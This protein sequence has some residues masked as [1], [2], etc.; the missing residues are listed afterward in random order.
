MD[1]RIRDSVRDFYGDAAREQ[2]PA[3]CCPTSYSKEDTAHIPKEVLDISYGCGSPIG[4]AGVREGETVLDLGSGGGIDCFIA[5]KKVGSSGRVIGVDMTDDM[6][7]KAKE[8]EREVAEKLGFSNVEFKKG[9][10]EEIPVEDGSIDLVTSNCV[11]N[12]SHDKGKVMEEVYRILRHKGRF[13]ISDVVSEKEVPEKM[14]AD[15][16]LWG[17][18]ISGAL[19]EDD[20]IDMSRKAGFYGLHVESRYLYHEVEGMSFHSITLKGYKFDK[21]AECLYKGQYAIYHGPF[22]SVHDDEGH[23]Y[24]AGTPVEICTD[25][26]EKLSSAPYRGL[27]TVVDT[28]G[29]VEGAA[30]EPDEG[31]G[32]GG[33]C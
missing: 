1:G 25:T 13:C 31:G 12:L 3:L 4:E 6:L 28:D 26:A 9:F 19:K 24:P 29:K 27:F 16:K 32:D 10:L 23:E 30:C 18:C 22:K 5:A 11:V 2:M 15:R 8:A 21:G 14:R 20:F 17:E 33:C 7:L